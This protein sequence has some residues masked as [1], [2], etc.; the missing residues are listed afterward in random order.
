[1]LCYILDGNCYHCHK[2]SLFELIPQANQPA[3]VLCFLRKHD[4][5]CSNVDFA[6]WP[7]L[8]HQKFPMPAPSILDPMVSRSFNVYY[9]A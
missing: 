7:F 9:R 3:G 6:V 4:D 2:F 8:W 1:M 5:E